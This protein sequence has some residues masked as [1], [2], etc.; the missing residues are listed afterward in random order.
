MLQEPGRRA[1]H[2][3]RGGILVIL[4][5]VCCTFLL[6]G[7][8]S[9]GQLHTLAGTQ[10]KG[11]V[12]GGQQPV[13][14]ASIQLYAAGL[15]GNGAVAV[16]LLSPNVVTT[17]KN[18]AF[19]ITGD[20]TCPTATAQVYLVSRGGN[21]GLASGVQNQ[22]LVFVAALGDCG[23]LTSSTYVWM[24]E[25]TTVAAA[26]ALSPFFGSGALAGASSTN[27]TGLRNAFG[28]AASLANIATGTAPGGSLPTGAIVETAKVNTLANALAG[29][30]NSDGG[31]ACTPLFTA[32]AVAGVAPGNVFD[33]ALN[34]VRNPGVS[35]ARIFQAVSAN[36][37]F[38]PTLASAPSDWTMSITYRNGGLD[39][40]A[41]L[42]IDSTG[43]VWVANYFGA[44]VSKF[45]PLGV[46]AAP[47]GFPGA[48][49]NQSYGVAIDPFDNAW[50]TNEQ[51]VS[52]AGNSHYGSVS[53]FN[54][55]GTELSGN[56]FTAGGLYYP[57]S[58]AAT[59]AG[60][61][62]AAD[63]GGSAA[64]LLA[65]DGSAISPAPG[66][67]A[68][69]LPFTSAVALDAGGDAWFATQQGAARVSASGVVGSFACCTGPAGIAVDPSGNVWIADYGAYAVVELN[70]S[71]AVAHT[72]STASAPVSP[73]GIAVDGAGNIWAANYYGDSV[74]AI[75]GATAALRSPVAGFGIDAPLNE[76]YALAIDASGNLWFSNA[77]NDTLTEIVGLAS[78]VKTPLLGPA[79]QP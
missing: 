73:Q 37:P 58:V 51:S 16:N 39:V 4:A 7:C 55:Q 27:L 12:H 49:L 62:W 13:S 69:Q 68:S 50:V 11:Q 40:P 60:L 72:I 24:N 45:S 63:Y 18:G 10:L 14:G 70:A 17:D 23:T 8:G 77:G 5:T 3:L 56:G 75:T 61:I 42:A 48:G 31:A 44:A 33:A 28:T 71:G 54:A 30:V 57:V 53:K 74:T 1:S 36:A 21:P 2:G 46:P 65:N 67:A 66:Y 79:A 22:A 47:Q 64:T 32:T 41:A 20:Y 52:A 59:P 6:A 34:V 76:P 26:W 15:S 29:C 78:P 25:V 43:S 38:Q 35:V 19:S 9:D